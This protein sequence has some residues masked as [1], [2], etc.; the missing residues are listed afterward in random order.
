MKKSVSENNAIIKV[1]IIGGGSNTDYLMSLLEKM[2]N[3]DINVV[4]TNSDINVVEVT[5]RELA[6][7]I[8][9][10]TEDPVSLENTLSEEMFM[11]ELN[12]SDNEDISLMIHTDTI[13]TSPLSLIEPFF[14]MKKGLSPIRPPPK[15]LYLYQI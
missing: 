10:I 2:T 9:Q 11:P 8:I 4:E 6:D 14:H 5:E 7:F 3:S 15:Y 12:I 1:C 13:D